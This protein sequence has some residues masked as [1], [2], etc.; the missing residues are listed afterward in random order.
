MTIRTTLSL[1]V[2]ALVI[3]WCAGAM[4][5]HGRRPTPTPAPASPTPPAQQG[6]VASQAGDQAQA[7]AA[8]LAPDL[9]RAQATI[10]S[11]AQEIDRLRSLVPDP[12]QTDPCP[13]LRALSAA[14]DIQITQQAHALDLCGQRG[15]ALQAEATARGNAATAYQEE[16]RQLRMVVEANPPRPWAVGVSY[17]TDGQRGL[18]AERDIWRFRASAE[19]YHTT[20]GGLQAGARLGWR[21]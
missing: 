2:A 12:P 4:S 7:K 5:C 8:S 20:S 15:D 18:W 13:E 9:A 1:L 14:Q 17:G 19:V 16:A 10:A 6:Q 11:Q 21:F 3:G